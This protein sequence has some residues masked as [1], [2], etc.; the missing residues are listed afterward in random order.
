M[1]PPPSSHPT[2]PASGDLP[3]IETLAAAVDRARIGQWSLDVSTGDLIVSNIF[4]SI[5]DWPNDIVPDEGDLIEAVHP[6]DRPLF[7]DHLASG[8]E[9][10]RPFRL[11]HRMTT[12]NGVEIIVETR[13]APIVGSANE[14]VRVAAVTQQT[15][16]G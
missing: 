16:P 13:G 6:D 14:V 15:A 9:Q 5:L 1:K 8:V 7:I 3:D 11:S 4:R 10:A 2:N 12:R